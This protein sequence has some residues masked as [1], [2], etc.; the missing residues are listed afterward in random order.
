MP[1]RGHVLQ[2]VPCLNDHF[3]NVPKACY[4]NESQCVTDKIKFLNQPFTFTLRGDGYYSLDVSGS[5]NVLEVDSNYFNIIPKPW[6]NSDAQLWT[7]EGDNESGW[8]FVSKLDTTKAL[9]VSIAGNE[10]VLW[11]NHGGDNQRF[12]RSSNCQNMCEIQGV[13]CEHSSSNMQ[14]ST[15]KCLKTCPSG[16]ILTNC[17]TCEPQEFYPYDA[18][19][20]SSTQFTF[21]DAVNYCKSKQNM[22]IATV[23]R[24]RKLRR[25]L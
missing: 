19:H 4:V 11:R 22:Q 10:L 13:L 15:Y 12:I 5:F 8:L 2:D 3:N 24:D 7:I 6:T 16:Y 21:D 1:D 9:D 18:Y 25:F 17:N 23:L 14:D 20:V